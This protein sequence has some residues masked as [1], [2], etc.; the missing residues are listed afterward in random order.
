MRSPSR[1]ATTER[2]LFVDSP[3]HAPDPFQAST[4][5]SRKDSIVLSSEKKAVF[6]PSA[7]ARAQRVDAPLAPRKLRPG[8]HLRPVKLQHLAGRVAG[9]PGPAGRPTG[10]RRCTCARTSGTGAGVA[11]LERRISVTRGAS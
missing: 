2:T 6:A 11:V 4:C 10:A 9:P 1:R 3:G 5:P 7:E 8:G